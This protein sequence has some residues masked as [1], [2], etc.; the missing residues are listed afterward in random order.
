MSAIITFTAAVR[1]ETGG[2]AAGRLRA[3]GKVPVTVSRPGKASTHASARSHEV[4]LE[5]GVRDVIEGGALDDD[6]QTLPCA[7]DAGRPWCG[8]IDLRGESAQV[9]THLPSQKLAVTAND[10]EDVVEVVGNPP[11][12]S[13]HRLHL[14][15]LA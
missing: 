1:T 8:E 12:Q 6:G 4:R 2:T 14:L 3:A 10:T 5:D 11:R 9:P 15:Y 13:A 7:S